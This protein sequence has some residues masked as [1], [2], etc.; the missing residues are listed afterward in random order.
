V[1]CASR[2]LVND[3]IAMEADSDQRKAEHGLEAGRSSAEAV[4]RLNP[5]S[6]DERVHGPR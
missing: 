6:D 5:D 4:L 3:A 2:R 1:L